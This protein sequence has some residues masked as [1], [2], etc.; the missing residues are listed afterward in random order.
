L[1]A[2]LYTD[3]HK[4]LDLGQDP[5]SFRGEPLWTTASDAGLR[6]GLFGPMQSWPPLSFPAGGF[7]VPD[8]FSRTS[9][10]N[11]PSL[12]RFQEFNLS[13]TQDNVFTSQARIKPVDTARAGID[14][15]M[16]GLSTSSVVR[17]STHLL[18][19]RRDPRYRACRAMMQVLPSFDLYWRLQRQTSPH[20]S[21]FFTNHVAGTM[22]RYWGD[23]VPG[24]AEKFDYAVDSVFKTFIIEAMD[25]FD[26]QLRRMLRRASGRPNRMVLVASSMG[27]GPIPHY[28][29]GATYILS[30]AAQL[31][32]TLG[33]E[34]TEI[35]MSMYPSAAILFETEEIANSAVAPLS[36]VQ[37]DDGPVLRDFRV[38]GRTVSFAV[39]CT[40]SIDSDHS[41]GVTYVPA[42]A[43]APVG[44]P[45]GSLGLAIERRLGGSNTAYHVP[46]GI[47]IC[48]RDGLEPNGSRQVV[49][50]LDVA[51]SILDWLGVEPSASMLGQPSI[52][53]QAPR[54]GIP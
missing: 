9:A 46:E 11:P 29:L 33:F 3:G 4:S 17:L 1:H 51:P 31:M 47:L 8:T 32:T 30:D 24:Y 23:G 53:A 43:T 18:N 25:L 37:T 48:L 28:E 6:V 42:M 10:T 41:Q 13:M 12:R 27:Q 36:S 39:D 5:N 40:R 54:P 52:W 44:A 20:L 49:S 15:L 22:H 34:R 2:S 38:A 45:L 50:I 21:I 35:L 26:N 7:H 16:K 19:E 14:M